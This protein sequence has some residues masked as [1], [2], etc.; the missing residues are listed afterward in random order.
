MDNLNEMTFTPFSYQ[1]GMIA[2]LRDTPHA[3]LFAG[4]GLG[5]TPCT[6]EAYRQLRERGDFKGALII[7]P[8]RVCSV[9]WPDQVARWGFDFKVANLRTKEGK[10]A[11]L[12]GSADI[13]LINFE[14]VSGR[15]S[16]KGFLDEF[17]GKDMPVDTL[18]IDELSCL[19][20]NS[21][22]TK[23]VIKARK[24]FK[25]VHGLTGTPSPNGLMD[26]FYQLKVLDGGARLGK[27]ITHFKTRWFDSDYMGYNFTPKQHAHQ[28]INASIADICLVRRSEEHLDIPDCNVI[29]EN[30]TLPAKVMKQYKALERQLVIDID[31]TVVDAQ[32]AATLVNKL[33]QF[34]AG[35]VYDENGETLALH[36]AKHKT[37]TKILSTQAPVLVLTRYK[38]EMSALLEAFP[39]AQAFDE[40]RMDDWRAGKIPVWV[41]NP[42]SLSHGIDGIQD[43]CS[44]IVWMSL[45]YSLE[46]YEQTNARILRTGQGK[47]ATIYRIMAAESIDWV[48]ASALENKSEGQSTLMASVG[49]L[50]R[51]NQDAQQDS[52]PSSRSHDQPGTWRGLF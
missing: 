29:D 5:K 3:A 13:Y 32:S 24:H 19:K 9:T 10:Q 6:L 8:L 51:A 2:H 41:A 27:F 20:A 50:Q 30:V 34:T 16:K 31:D 42:A 38:S 47:A 46:Q 39:E 45:T 49:M 36:T 22:R 12:D 14:L 44:T 7:A 4:M 25:R 11:W 40:A 26:L 18:L 37:L 23:A 52:K 21:K 48:V 28:E 35:S 15:G 33:Q 17:V 1:Q 43:S